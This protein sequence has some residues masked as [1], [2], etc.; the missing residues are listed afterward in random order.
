MPVSR[1]LYAGVLSRRRLSLITGFRKGYQM[2][3]ISHWGDEY[4]YEEKN[5]VCNNNDIDAVAMG[6]PF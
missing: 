4:L 3:T 2:V 6:G 1:N 5:A